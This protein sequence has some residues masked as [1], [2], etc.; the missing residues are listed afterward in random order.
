MLLKT[1]FTQSGETA[2][3]N[4]GLISDHLLLLRYEK[5]LIWP[6]MRECIRHS[7]IRLF[8]VRSLPSQENGLKRISPA[9]TVKGWHA[10]KRVPHF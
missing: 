1:V 10:L 8:T 6:K 9:R 3:E 2:G 4:F 5:K 7:H